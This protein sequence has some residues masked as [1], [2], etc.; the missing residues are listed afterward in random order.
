MS[1]GG[2]A[3]PVRG[4][5]RRRRLRS[6]ESVR[7]RGRAA[8]HG[9]PRGRGRRGAHGRIL[10]GPR[11]ADLAARSPQGEDP[12]R[13]LGE[14]EQDR[15]H[16]LVRALRPGEPELGED[17]V[18]HLLH[19]V[20]REN[21]VD[22]IAALFLPSAISRSTSP[23]RGVRSSIG[24]DLRAEPPGDQDVDD[25]RIDHRASTGDRVDGRAQL[26]DVLQA[27]LQEVGAPVRS[28]LEE[29]QCVLRLG[30]LAQHDDADV[31][32]E[33]A[34]AVGGLQPLVELRPAACGCR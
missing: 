18:D 24:E 34:Q 33:V 21:S 8:G 3:R 14:V 26:V 29:P 22:A 5:R 31:R 13:L 19:G 11:D 32:V 9:R 2:R 6:G 16:A 7:P 10:P 27:L 1:A 30:V 28:S 25:Q 17:R 20:L 23:S 12:V 4:R 15:L